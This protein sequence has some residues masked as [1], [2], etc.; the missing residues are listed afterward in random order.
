MISAHCNLH[1]WG[2]T[3]IT[4]TCHHIWLIF[5]FIREKISLYRS[6]WLELLTSNDLPASASQ[7]AG[8]TESYSVARCQV[9]V[10][11]HNLGLLQSPSWASTLPPRLEYSGAIST[12][13]NFNLP[14]SRDPPTS[15]FQIDNEA[16]N[17][18]NKP[19]YY[20][21]HNNIKIRSIDNTTI[22]SKCS[23]EK[24]S[25]VS[26]FASKAGNDFLFL[27]RAYQKLRQAKS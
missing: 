10:Q 24:Q 13:C 3:E 8:I 17:S 26:H 7:S 27:R 14:V 1:L 11:W 12:H 21:R 18:A 6:S 20:Q 5:D 19:L 2:S 4:S 15:A 16:Q 9:G 25:H 23:S 22:T